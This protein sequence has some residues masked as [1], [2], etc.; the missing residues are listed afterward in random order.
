MQELG[1][2]ILKGNEADVAK[3]EEIIQRLETMSVGSLPAIHVLTLQNVDSEAM[4]TLLTSVYEE[5]TE[6]RQ[7]G[8][9]NRKTAAFIPVIQPNAILILS[10][11]IERQSILESGR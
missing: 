2:L 8:S 1:I 9:E 6:L 4:A 3:V 11:E 10:S 7:R 5:L